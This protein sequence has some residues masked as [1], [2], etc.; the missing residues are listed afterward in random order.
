M[1]HCRVWAFSPLFVAPRPSTDLHIPP[2]SNFAPRPSTD[3]HIPL[4]SDFAAR[5]STNLH[6]AP[7]CDFVPRPSTDLHISP[8]SDFAPWLST[9]LKLLH[10]FYWQFHPP[11]NN[12]ANNEPSRPSNE[13]K[14][15]NMDKYHASSGNNTRCSSVWTLIICT[16][17]CHILAPNQVIHKMLV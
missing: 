12:L 15:T 11:Y 16:P 17:I 14:V 10:K 13:Y 8:A 9:D 6:S 2:A 4:A 1:G 3:L 5:P 7:A